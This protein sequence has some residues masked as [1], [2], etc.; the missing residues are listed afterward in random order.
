MMM[1]AAAPVRMELPGWAGLEAKARMDAEMERGDFFASLSGKASACG[2]S[3]AKAWA[4]EAM[5]AYKKA[6]ALAEKMN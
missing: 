1:A 4:A 2:S 6:A 5:E 3:S